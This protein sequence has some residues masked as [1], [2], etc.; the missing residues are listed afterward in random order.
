MGVRNTPSSFGLVSRTIH[1]AMAAAILG[2]LPFGLWLEGQKI[3][4][5][6]LWLYGL[7]KSIGM[8]LLA[9]V[10]VRIVWHRIS[11]PPHQLTQSIASWQIRAARWAHWALYLL[12]VLVPLSGWIG[13]AATG[14]DV[15]VWGLTLPSVWPQ[16]EGWDKGGFA[17]H[18]ILTKLLLAV[19]LLHFAGALHRAFVHRDRTLTRMIRG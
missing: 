8:T 2:M 10:L 6:N 14:I 16:T 1:W 18:S 15:T 11:P 12:M 3:G 7:H 17:A 5:S 19:V 4:L 13:S 9:L